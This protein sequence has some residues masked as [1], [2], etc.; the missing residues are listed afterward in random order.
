MKVKDIKAVE[1]FGIIVHIELILYFYRKL[2]LL[3]LLPL[4]HV[5]PWKVFLWSSC[6]VRGSGL[7]SWNASAPYL[8]P[9]MS[10]VKFTLLCK[11]RRTRNNQP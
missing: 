8:P 6:R 7:F 1:M 3:L 10:S 2:T 9:F 4:S 11:L 5:C